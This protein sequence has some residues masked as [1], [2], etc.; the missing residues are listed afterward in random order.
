MH[1][2]YTVG[3]SGKYVLSCRAS[4]CW[5]LGQIGS[6]DDSSRHIRLSQYCTSVVETEKNKEFV[7]VYKQKS[8][9][10]F[11]QDLFY[12]IFYYICNIN[13]SCENRWHLNQILVKFLF[14]FNE[15]KEKKWWTTAVF[16]CPNHLAA[17]QFR[18]SPS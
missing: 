18:L 14:S 10:Q 6:K 5:P 4:F 17:A 11:V 3:T 1:V 12:F 13:F 16:G 2:F 9:G 7:S 8:K 15:Q